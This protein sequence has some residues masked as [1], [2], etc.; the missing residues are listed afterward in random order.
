MMPVGLKK[1]ASRR[2]LSQIS[3][4][5]IGPK[6]HARRALAKTVSVS[7]K[8]STSGTLPTVGADVD[9]EMTEDEDIYASASEMMVGYFA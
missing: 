6:H 7:A 1:R 3:V 9:L 8:Q 2:D 5:V 4:P